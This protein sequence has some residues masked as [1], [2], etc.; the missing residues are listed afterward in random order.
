MNVKNLFSCDDF[1]LK[2][3]IQVAT[4]F[5][6]FIFLIKAVF[7]V[8]KLFCFFLPFLILFFLFKNY[9]FFRSK[10]KMMFCV[11]PV[12]LILTSYFIFK[13]P[14]FFFL[15][16]AAPTVFFLNQSQIKAALDFSNFKALKSS[17]NF[18]IQ[19]SE[20][21]L[22]ATLLAASSFCFL[23]YLVKS[24]FF[25]VFPLGLAF[26][27]FNNHLIENTLRSVLRFLN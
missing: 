14:L 13:A 2:N 23:I 24:F 27:F 8:L 10:E 16:L 17:L 19:R 21:P 4:I 7:F 11:M 25:L 6:L 5:V 18:H 26:V 20:N 12:I 22:L 9:D 15:L 3:F 1:H